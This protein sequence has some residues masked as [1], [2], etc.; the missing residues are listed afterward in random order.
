MGFEK[1]KFSMF[2]IKNIINKA[3]APKKHKIDL[4]QCCTM[5]I[6]FDQHKVINEDVHN[7]RYTVQDTGM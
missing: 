6:H 2:P 7:C 3:E 4:L 1:L 5:P